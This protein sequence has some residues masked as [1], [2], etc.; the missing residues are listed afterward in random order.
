VL[1]EILFCIPCDSH[2]DFFIA[3]YK[4]YK[5]CWFS[6]ALFWCLLSEGIEVE[7]FVTSTEF[8][9]W[10]I[11]IISNKKTKLQMKLLIVNQIP[12]SHGFE[13]TLR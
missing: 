7:W 4:E 5:K 1:K 11:I 8:V 3:F 6:F 2:C 13:E 9:A 12:N 10:L